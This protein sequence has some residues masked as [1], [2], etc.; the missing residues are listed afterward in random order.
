M[1]SFVLLNQNTTMVSALY[2]SHGCLSE[3]VRQTLHAEVESFL[4]SVIPGQYMQ[5]RVCSRVLLRPK[6]AILCKIFTA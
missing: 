6:L 3:N 4:A 2:G 5:V 1:P